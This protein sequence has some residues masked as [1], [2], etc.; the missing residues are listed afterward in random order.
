MQNNATIGVGKGFWID[1][2]WGNARTQ[3][4][5]Q[6]NAKGYVSLKGSGSLER[7]PLQKTSTQ[8]GDALHKGFV[9]GGSF[10]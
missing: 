5:R 2:E 3:K 9:R 10:H 1:T 6:M 7:D 4:Q 8:R